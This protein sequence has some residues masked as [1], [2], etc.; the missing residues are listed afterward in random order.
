MLPP[1][2]GVEPMFR[3][4]VVLPSPATPVTPAPI[5]TLPWPVV[6]KVARKATQ[7]RVRTGQ[8]CCRWSALSPVAVFEKPSVLSSERGIADSRIAGR[9]V[10]Q[11]RLRTQGGVKGIVGVAK[12]RLGADGY[13]VQSRWY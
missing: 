13:V 5:Q 2:I 6:R 9:S 3:I 11:Q 7:S 12:E 1:T 4:R 10:V 8:W